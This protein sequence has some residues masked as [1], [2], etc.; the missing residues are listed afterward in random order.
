MG[1][2]LVFL[3]WFLQPGKV[4]HRN[5]RDVLSRKRLELIYPIFRIELS[6]DWGLG[7]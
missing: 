1:C 5:D 4:D 2:F 3:A 6:G 7:I